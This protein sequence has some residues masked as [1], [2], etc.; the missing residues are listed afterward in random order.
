MAKLLGI[1]KYNL[2]GKTY[3]ITQAEIDTVSNNGPTLDKDDWYK[4]CFKT[5]KSDIKVH[6]ARKQ[7]R[8]CAYCRTLI[9]VDGYDE[10]IEHILP[11]NH[12]P[13]WMFV[14]QNLVIACKGCN[15]SKG[16]KDTMNPHVNHFG[17][18]PANCPVSSIDFKIFNPHFDTWEDHFTIED[19]FFLSTKANSKGP[20]TYKELNM[21]RYH[22]IIDYI[23]QLSLRADSYKSITKR[24]RKV[25]DKKK[26]EEMK[27]A[28]ESLK[29]MIDEA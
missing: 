21:H 14:Q 13:Q 7:K 25:K 11:R 1:L 20:Y 17:H 5:I 29:A 9:N 16:P 4:S 22:I 15:S 28:I 12:R 26:Q 3:P 8:R 10:A 6:Y 18:L 2:I 27:K 23:D 24:I 19:N